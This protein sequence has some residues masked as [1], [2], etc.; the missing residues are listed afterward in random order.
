[1]RAGL[2]HLWL[3]S[4]IAALPI[5]AHAEWQAT[6]VVKTYA[7][8]GKT[9]LELYESIGKRGPEAKGGKRTIA[10]PISS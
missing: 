2:L 4:A 8:S 6:E 1:M 10:H 9:G 7:I 5:A 3:A